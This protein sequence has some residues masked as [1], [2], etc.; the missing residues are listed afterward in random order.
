MMLI[1]CVYFV[2]NFTNDLDD[3][4][5]NSIEIVIKSNMSDRILASKIVIK[6]SAFKVKFTKLIIKN[7]CVDFFIKF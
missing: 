4:Y 6:M 5:A 2:Q 3:K 1:I 7:F